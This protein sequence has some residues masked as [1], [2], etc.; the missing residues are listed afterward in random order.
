MLIKIRTVYYKDYWIKII[1]KKIVFSIFNYITYIYVYIQLKK[2]LYFY[3]ERELFFSLSTL[4]ILKTDLILL[5]YQVDQFNML[6]PFHSFPFI[7]RDI[8]TFSP[9][10]ETTFGLNKLLWQKR[11][12]SPYD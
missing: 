11:R 4:F 9:Q 1:L 8:V 2:N 3:L 6:S 10:I 7:E 5:M 12:Y